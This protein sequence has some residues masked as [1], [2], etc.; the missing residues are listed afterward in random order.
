MIG[1]EKCSCQFLEGLFGDVEAGEA[2]G[3]GDRRGVQR[4]E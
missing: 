1:A 2:E 4:G 3:D